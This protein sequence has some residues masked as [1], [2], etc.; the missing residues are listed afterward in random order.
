ML[1]FIYREAVFEDCF[2][3]C[4]PMLEAD[5]PTYDY[6]CESCGSKFELRLKFSD[7]VDQPCSSKG[8]GAIAKRQFSV[9]P[10]VF[11]G[12]GWY[13]NDYGKKGSSSG[14]GTDSVGSEK[15]S[16]SSDSA[17]SSV[18]KNSSKDDKDSGSSSKKEST[19]TPS[20]KPTSS[21]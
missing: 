13:V 17:S 10:I 19:S 16:T 18:K 7:D 3:I 20:T 15:D 4:K 9:V 1:D 8:C 21:D 2:F 12:S 11:K 5:L 6:S 14:K